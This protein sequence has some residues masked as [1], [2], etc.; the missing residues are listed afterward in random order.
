MGVILRRQAK[1]LLPRS[2]RPLTIRIQYGDNRYSPDPLGVDTVPK[3]YGKILR[4]RLRMTVVEWE[5]PST[6]FT[7][8]G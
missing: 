2:L 4:L 1:D 5:E 3:I 8:S 7:R 6:R